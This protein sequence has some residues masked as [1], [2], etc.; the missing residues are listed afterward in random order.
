MKYTK[1]IAA[2]FL[3][4]TLVLSLC[5]CGDQ[6]G[7]MK[8]STI[9]SA[10][11]AKYSGTYTAFGVS[12]DNYRSYIV[13]LGGESS[14]MT[15]YEDGTGVMKL[16]TSENDGQI[17]SWYVDKDMISIYISG[18]RQNGTVKDDIIELYIASSSITMYYAKDGAD[19]SSYNVLSQEAFK[20]S[21]AA[22][23]AN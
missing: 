11:A 5:A 6:S 15:L 1:R 2:L 23:Q 16:S 20:E 17:E 22:N 8:G 7:V 10:V 3:C 18:E 14:E 19:T 9:D 12:H 4:V 13:D 21:V